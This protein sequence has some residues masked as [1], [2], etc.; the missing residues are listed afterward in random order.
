MLDNLLNFEVLGY[1]AAACTTFSFLPQAIKV[2]KTGDTHSL[3]L[4]MYLV[5][6]LGVMLWLVYAIGIHDGPLMA[7][8][9]VTLLFV[10]TILA[11]KIKNMVTTKEQ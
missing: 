5:F 3:S 1:A 4:G 6:A 7:A 8:N 2:I 10:L 11:L 9:G